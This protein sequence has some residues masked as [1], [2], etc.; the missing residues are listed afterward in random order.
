MSKTKNISI[1]KIKK[2]NEEIVSQTNIVFNIN[3]FN[4]TL[5]EL[6][7]T[8]ISKNIKIKIFVAQMKMKKFQIY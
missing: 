1:I 2:F 5:R 6:L 3:L 8:E 4:L 7:K